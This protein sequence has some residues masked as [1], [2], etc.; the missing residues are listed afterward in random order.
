MGGGGEGEGWEGE[1][2]VVGKRVGEVEEEAQRGEEEREEREERGG[3]EERGRVKSAACIYEFLCRK[4]SEEEYKKDSKN[5]KIQQ[6]KT[7]RNRKQ[8]QK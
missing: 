4:N 8:K 7:D 3:G 5:I 6:D 2:E 1:E